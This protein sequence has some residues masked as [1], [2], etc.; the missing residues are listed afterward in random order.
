MKSRLDELAEGVLRGGYWN[1]GDDRT[2]ERA[3]CFEAL[4]LARA[5]YA[6]G[7]GK[8]LRARGRLVA[9]LAEH[10]VN[11]GEGDAGRLRDYV[12]A[13]VEVA[14][15]A[16]S[17]I[18]APLALAVARARLLRVERGDAAVAVV[19][20]TNARSRDP[21][22][23]RLADATAPEAPFDDGERLDQMR[24]GICAWALINVAG[25][26][27]VELSQRAAIAFDEAETRRLYTLGSV[28]ALHV[29]SGR[30]VLQGM[31]IGPDAEVRVVP[32]WYD[33]CFAALDSAGSG[34][35]RVDFCVLVLF[36]PTSRQRNE[37]RMMF[38]LLANFDARD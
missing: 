29:P 24:D 3:A 12:A 11:A 9:A 20:R 32:G 13:L 36:A 15:W 22:T 28:R 38:E 14:P 18:H 2:E 25:E 16:S 34:A 33:V 30:L 7:K 10:G 6:S 23:Y 35:A 8:E 37:G 4:T 27:D 21:H 1:R 26:V 5:A 19:A 17:P 31:A